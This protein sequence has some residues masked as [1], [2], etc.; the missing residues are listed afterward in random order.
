MGSCIICGSSVDGRVCELHEE[1]V[2]FEFRGTEPD[3][4]TPNRYYRGTVDGYAEFGIFVDIGDSVTGLLHK[5]ELDQR[6][7]SMDF[8]PGDTI[9][10][11]VQNV[12][13][14]GNVDLGWSIR[15]EKSRFRGALVDD[16][17]AG[18]E[19]L[20][21]E[22]SADEQEQETGSD[23]EPDIGEPEPVSQSQEGSEPET[24]AKA[25]DDSEPEAEEDSEEPTAEFEQATVD[26]LD[27]LVG[28]RVRLEG[29]IETARQTSGPT[30]FELRDETGTVEC[31]AFEE[32]GV[33][34]YPEVDEGDIVRIEGE[35]ERRRGDIQVET[36]ALVILTDEERDAV[37]ERMEEAVV[38]RARPAEFEPLTDD[39]AVEAVAEPI[40]D[41][42][43]AIRRAV[44][45]G[46]PIVVRHAGTADG[47]AASSAIERATLPLIREEHGAGEAEYHYFDRR[48]LEG[49]VYDMNDATKDITT[50]LQNRDRHGE[51]LPL[52]V[53]VGAGGSAESIDGFDLLDTYDARRVVVDERTIEE[54]VAEAVDILVSPTLEGD[55]ETTATVLGA[56]VGA[57]VNPDV[58][59]ELGH[60]PAVSFWEDAPDQ[61]TA[62]AA[63]TGYSA[64][65]TRKLREAVALEAFYQ[66]YEDKRELISDLLFADEAEDP[67][68]LAEHISEQFRTRLESEIETAEANLEERTVDGETIL[69]L[70]TDS[71][72]HQYEF[73]PEPLLLDE[74]FRRHRDDAGALIGVATD[75]AYIRSQSGVDIRGVAER[76]GENAPG[77]ALDVRGARDGRIEFLSGKRDAAREAL[78]EALAEEL[79]ALQA[80]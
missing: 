64:D 55:Y 36:E 70:D 15:Q 3:E 61:Y 69:V 63:E 52:F 65:D 29:E 17:D 32:A 80:A 78:I 57:H 10:V 28:E 1:D 48:P 20:D 38:Q 6:L 11:Q 34:A 5:S 79:S 72:T 45:E 23:S 74:L 40:R 19:L 2:V 73:P 51:T 66:S 39:P 56:T 25:E 9:F 12:R 60:L 46:R 4:L 35:V 16:P 37:T 26:H 58:R 43:T 59:T 67:V 27:E 41:A 62:L 22:E 30:V 13:D 47:Y 75:E 8:D 76:A 53:F 54:G 44:I 77:A 18:Q 31:A 68:G 50:M 33:R 7:D 24:E 49:S 21:E 42:A 14:N 71:Y